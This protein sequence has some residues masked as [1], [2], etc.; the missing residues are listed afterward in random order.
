MKTILRNVLA[1]VAGLAAGSV[2]NMGLIMVGGTVMPPPAGAD[3]T[4]MEALQQTMHLFEPRHFVLPFVAH[5]LGT[6]VGAWV[7]ATLA[8]TRKVAMALVVGVVFLFGGI[9]NVLMLPAP[10]WFEAVDLVGAYLP[11]AWLGASLAKAKHGH[12]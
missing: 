5:A 9:A 8:V 11:M 7:A 3:V 2:V 1:V 6:A 10:L 12:V 4:S